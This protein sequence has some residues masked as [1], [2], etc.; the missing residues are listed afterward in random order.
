M[1]I[2]AYLSVMSIYFVGVDAVG[3]VDVF[4]VP[5]IG[6]GQEITVATCHVLPNVDPGK[7]CEDKGNSVS[8]A[9]RSCMCL[10]HA[11]LP[12][13]IPT[14]C[15][16]RVRVWTRGTVLVYH[17]GHLSE[18]PLPTS[19]H[20]HPIYTPGTGVDKGNSASVSCRTSV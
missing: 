9:C 4:T 14:L 6:G 7:R 17:A 5:A 16:P 18:P 10:N 13:S 20:P 11:S 8:I 1:P 15:T 2:D 19:L 12:P 3:E